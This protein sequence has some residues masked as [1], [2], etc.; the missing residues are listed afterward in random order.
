[1]N[2]I[3]ITGCA[4]FIGSQF[5]KKMLDKYKIIGIDNF[6][7]YYS[8]KLKKKRIATLK[9]YK[10]FSFFKIDIR[11]KNKLNKIIRNNN[12]KYVFHFA[13][14]AG[15]RYSKIDPY[16]YT[17]TNV[18]G[19]INLLNCL[20]SKKINKIFLSSSSSVYGESNNF[21]LKEKERLKPKNH[22]AYSKKIN[23][24][25]GFSFSKMYNLKIYMLRFFTVYG[26]WGRPDMFFFKLFK[27]LFTKN[28]FELNNNGNHDRDFTHIEDVCEM[29]KKLAS[30]NIKK[31]FNIFNICSSNP[32]N[33]KKILYFVN[34]KISKVNFKFKSRNILDVKKTHGSND[35]ILKLINHKSFRNHYKSIIK[36]YEWY[37]NNKI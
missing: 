18:M 35:K 30:A 21:P 8:I 24:I 9:K 33:I 34:K 15:V 36:L 12:F 17:S 4:G 5:S 37:K 7:N 11:N 3:L 2:K 1:M 26:E 23:E 28:S 27:T 19:T 6:D 31:K 10:N 20:K 22:Y 25:T 13:A 16:K 14:Q 29:L 32:I